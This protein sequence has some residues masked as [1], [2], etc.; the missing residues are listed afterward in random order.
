MQH[1]KIG[2][3]IA[4]SEEL[5]RWRNECRA[6]NTIAVTRVSHIVAQFLHA[7][8]PAVHHL[9]SHRTTRRRGSLASSPGSGAL[10][11]TRRANDD[12]PIALRR[13]NKRANRIAWRIFRS[14]AM[15]YDRP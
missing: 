9:P 4:N 7:A 12:P 6:C 14:S 3:I 11:Q 8:R 10:R 1:P 2:L 5:Q 13:E 15:R